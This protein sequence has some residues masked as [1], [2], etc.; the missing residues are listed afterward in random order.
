MESVA[1]QIEAARPL[2]EAGI[3]AASLLRLVPPVRRATRVDCALWDLE[4]KL[5]GD[6]G[7]SARLVCRRS[8]SPPPITISLG[9]P[10]AMA[11]QARAHAGRA[12]LK[13]KVGTGDD[14]DPI[15]AV[16]AA[17]PDAGIDPRR[18]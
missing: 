6:A 13:V 3:R 4:A 17:A 7:R 12:L 9:E 5:T 15:R 8:R 1:A 14:R 10:E 11:A 16:R 18:Q 2:I